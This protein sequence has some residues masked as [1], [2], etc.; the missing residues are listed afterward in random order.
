MGPSE[1]E[2]LWSS[3]LP[4]T[5]VVSHLYVDIPYPIARNSWAARR[6]TSTFLRVNVS[7]SRTKSCDPVYDPGRS[8]RGP[9]SRVTPL[10]DFLCSPHLGQ[11]PRGPGEG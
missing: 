6:R 3:V 11:D 9:G 1:G 5:W 2:S 8:A 7:D 10:I 4:M